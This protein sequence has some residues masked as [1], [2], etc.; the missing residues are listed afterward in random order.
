M[1]E[2]NLQLAILIKTEVTRALAD[3]EKLR[4]SA[5]RTREELS[6]P[7]AQVRS[8]GIE[9]ANA[10]TRELARS[11][12]AAAGSYSFLISA[13][14]GFI[15]LYTAKRVLETADAYRVLQQ[16]IRSA[17][18]E[19]GDYNQVSAEISRISKENRVELE[20]TVSTFQRLSI[21]KEAVGAT[22]KEMLRLTDL[23]QK[24]GKIGGS[25]QSQLTAGQLQFAQALST[26]RVQAEEINSVIENI[27]L[28]ARYIEKSLGLLP[29]TLKKAVVEGKVLS[30]DLL[31]ISNY[32]DEIDAK[33]ALFGPAIAGGLTNVQT[34]VAEFIGKLDQATGIT[35]GIAEG[36]KSA[37][38][39]IDSG[40]AE[41]F[42]AVIKQI[43][44]AV[45]AIGLAQLF[46]GATTSA[47]IFFAALKNVNG[48]LLLA[49]TRMTLLAA[50]AGALAGVMKLLGGPGG[51]IILAASALAYFI[52]KANAARQST[53]E[54]VDSLKA[55]RDVP[56][57]E[58]I[59]R[60]LAAGTRYSEVLKRITELEQERARSLTDPAYSFYAADE[61]ELERLR[62][63]E[64]RLK[65]A[66]SS[67]RAEIQ[68]Q[69]KEAATAGS[70]SDKPPPGASAAV[71]DL[72]RVSVEAQSR[73]LKAGLDAQLADLDRVQAQ[74][75]IS[76]RDY[77]AQRAAIQTQAI[78]AEIRRQQAALT[79]AKKDAAAGGNEQSVQAAKEKQIGI[80]AELTILRQQR[81]RVAITSAADEAQAEQQLATEL[82]QVRIRLLEAQGKSAEARTLAIQHEFEGLSK[83]LEIEGDAAGQAIVSK[84]INV[85]AARVQLDALQQQVDQAVSRLSNTEQGIQAQQ[86]AGVLTELQARQ[87]IV[88]AHKEAAAVIE[89]TI[90]K[91]ETLAAAI[92]SPE[93]L[94]G[95]EQ[96]K[97]KLQEVSTVTDDLAVRVNGAV[98]DGFAQLFEDFGSGAI[99]STSK[100]KAAFEDMGRSIIQ[101]LNQIASQKLAEALFSSLF[102]PAGATGGATPGG[103]FSSLFQGFA[104]GGLVTGPGTATSDSIPARLSP[105]EYVVRADAVRSIGV[106][107]L[108]RL[109]GLITPPKLNAGRLAFAA[110]GVVPAPIAVPAAQTQP[111]ASPI[112]AAQSVRMVLLDDRANIGDYLASSDGEKVL[113]QTLRRN[114]MTIKQILGG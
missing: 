22:N 75:L 79:E 18:D 46:G 45:G 50:P 84:L 9:R 57:D 17:T 101:T 66:I 16:R 8:D 5:K 58:A 90:P 26:G 72:A 41:H 30:A 34:S 51:L 110:G 2:R 39:A 43:G 42:L 48:A 27:P 12:I 112:G 31:K 64:K 113:V 3:F 53:D 70:Q 54:L 71:I 60:W 100:A 33:F 89:A 14:K 37:S 108:N 10:R 35:Q 106:S 11:N 59:R 91:A 19:T 4:G 104:G 32:G 92:G 95:V 1:A 99:T 38:K 69:S 55:L 63:E 96:M 80:E 62:A 68:R 7:G 103:F 74:N 78:D 98:Q 81:A 23:I 85:E 36:L 40:D 73:I 87:Q 83:R 6:K 13:A 88:A 44:I 82:E 77:Y 67:A 65:A 29:G 61:K 94:A 56:H 107:Y 111:H 25:T 86:T 24:L 20:S 102:G 28:V 105:G 49:Q 47:L 76:Y 52:I 15:S 97:T 21:A 114:S 93:A 109:N